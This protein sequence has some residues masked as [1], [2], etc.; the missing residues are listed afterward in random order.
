M[1]SISKKE[2]NDIAKKNKKYYCYILKNNYEP[3]INRTYNGLTN[4][5]N[6][7]IR[8]H[9]QEIKGGAR[10]TKRYGNKQWQI[11]VVISG[12]PDKINA[13]QCEW[14]IKYPDNRCKRSRGKF[15]TPEGRI[16]GLIKVLQSEKWTSNSTIVNRDIDIIVQIIP[17]YYDIICDATLPNNIK[18]NKCSFVDLMEI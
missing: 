10:Y 9:N 8:Q 18:I 13:L 14:R 6:R 15:R 1:T 3:D 7:R 11:Y 12:F 16:K 5:L 17:E 4:N 2:I